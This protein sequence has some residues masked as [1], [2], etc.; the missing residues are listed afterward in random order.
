VFSCVIDERCVFCLTD[1]T[2]PVAAARPSLCVHDMC[3]GA[4]SVAV[5]AQKDRGTPVCVKRRS[6]SL[7]GYL[8]IPCL[9]CK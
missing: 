2:A 3:L 8:F 9:K 4:Q 7:T 6:S 5:F 1:V